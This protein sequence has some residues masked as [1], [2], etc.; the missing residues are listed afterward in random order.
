MMMW[1]IGLSVA[2]V[3]LLLA[4][5]YLVIRL[6]DVKEDLENAKRELSQY[7]EVDFDSQRWA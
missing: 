6:I 1:I 2:V 4:V 5:A 7:Q 3:A